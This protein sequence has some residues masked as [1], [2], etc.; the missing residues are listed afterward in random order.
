MTIE[1]GRVWRRRGLLLTLLLAA[2]ALAGPTASPGLAQDAE[3]ATQNRRPVTVEQI[4]D[5]AFGRFVP[6]LGVPG[7]VVI[8]AVTGH[9][10]VEGGV[11]DFG[12]EHG[13]AEFLVRGEPGARVVITL[14]SEQSAKTGD[15]SGAIGLSDL[16][17]HPAGIAV[18][19]PDGT[20]IIYLG[21]RLNVRPGQPSGKYLGSLD[22]F[23]DYAA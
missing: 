8:D 20:L 14:P 15:E 16:A 19:G 10:T 5:L 21:A 11:T 13:R 3:D 2:V 9:K 23:V 7:A 18:W 6:D 4:A 12:G 22:S 17:S 1:G